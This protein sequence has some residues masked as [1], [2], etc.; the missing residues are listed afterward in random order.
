MISFMPLVFIPQ[1]IFQMPPKIPQIWRFITPFLLTGPK[2]SILMD[3]YFLFTYG[4]ALEKDSPRFSELGSFFTYVVFVMAFVTVSTM[5]SISA[6]NLL[7]RGSS[8]TDDRKNYPSISAR[9]VLL[10]EAVPEIE[11]DYLCDIR[12]VRF[13]SGFAGVVDM[14]GNAY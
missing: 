1:R 14:V 5:F 3:P 6:F 2:F 7:P 9:P 11:G 10:A 13:Q 12:V 4:S 8:P